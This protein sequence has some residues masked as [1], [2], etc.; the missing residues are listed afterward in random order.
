MYGGRIPDGEASYRADLL[1]SIICQ[2]NFKILTKLLNFSYIFPT[3]SQLMSGIV[4]FKA[5]G[6]PPR[7]FLAS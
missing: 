7:R 4:G 5:S 1:G 3:A 6:R 2:L